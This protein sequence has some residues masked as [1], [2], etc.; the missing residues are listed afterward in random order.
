M[1]D[2]I[3]VAVVDV[4]SILVAQLISIV[5]AS[6]VSTDLTLRE[7][8]SHD[9]FYRPDCTTKIVISPR[10]SKE[11]AA[12]VAATTIAGFD[13]HVRGGGMSYTDAYTPLRADSV[14]IDMTAMNRVLEVNETD[15]YVTVEAG[16]TWAEL[17][18][19][20]ES[21]GLR[22]P[23]WGPLS[24]LY[25]TIG[26]GLSQNNAFFGSGT[27]GTTSESL[28]SLKVVLADG[29]IID[30][31]SASTQGGRPFYRFYGPD[32]TGL[33]TG[34]AGAMGVKAEATFRLIDRPKESGFLS[35]AFESSEDSAAAMS[36]LSR[37]GVG[38]E[39]FGFDPGL[40][41]IAMSRGNWS[42]NLKTVASIAKAQK[43]IVAGVREAAK[44][45]VAGK[46]IVRRQEFSL[47]LVCDG[48]SEA[49]VNA[50]L[51][52][53]R[54][55]AANHQGKEIDNSIAKVIR[56]APFGPVDS[57]LGPNGERW[58]PTH[59]IVAHSDAPKVWHEMYALFAANAEQMD[60]YE[61]TFGFLT[62]TLASNGFL[63]EPVMVW[64]DELYPMHRH[65]VRAEHLDG[66]PVFADNPDAR[67]FVTEMRQ[68]LIKI[69]SKY[70]AV[71]FQVGKAYPYREHRKE[72]LWSLIETL[73]ASVD[74]TGKINPGCLGLKPKK[75]Q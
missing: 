2:S 8:Y 19:T 41:A 40:T 3:P 16:C 25:S 35:F 61:V 75:A 12:V 50:D 48:R 56:A 21:K 58:V 49:A 74:P 15:M 27:W 54:T 55:I 66:A 51:N 1:T 13:I 53:A 22:T 26:G 43:S 73:K 4:T 65:Y 69:F 18:T 68:K 36:A 17:N 46:S 31:G 63:I 14:M 33:F 37:A 44:T 34:D 59:G 28:T 39:V 6:Q 20:L 45:V 24:G 47:H 38:A 67:A 9:V 62:C 60:T 42:D 52:L 10:S 64:P 7:L 70:H 23:F 32:M 71:H 57:M 72:A 29:S 30:T 5:G 11:L